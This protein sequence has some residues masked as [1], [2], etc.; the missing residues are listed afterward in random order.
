MAAAKTG[1]GTVAGKM[2]L[3]LAEAFRALRGLH[4]RLLY[5]ACC[6]ARTFRATIGLCM[7]FVTCF[8][9]SVP[10]AILSKAFKKIE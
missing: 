5:Q 4:S 9:Y 8:R 1:R 6:A 7:Q 2:P 3:T 10:A